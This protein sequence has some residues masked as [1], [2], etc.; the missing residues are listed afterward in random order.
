MP[1]LSTY[2]PQPSLPNDGSHGQGPCGFPSS[3]A[4][5]GSHSQGPRG[6]PSSAAF[7]LQLCNLIFWKETKS[8]KCWVFYPN[9]EYWHKNLVINN[10]RQKGFD[11]IWLWFQTYK[12]SLKASHKEVQYPDCDA[13]IYIPSTVLWAI[14]VTPLKSRVRPRWLFVFNVLLEHWL[15]AV[16]KI[17]QLFMTANERHKR[18]NLLEFVLYIY[19][20]TKL[21]SK[22]PNSKF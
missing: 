7:I 12:N 20:N 15:R 22:Y 10:F 18:R 4:N 8:F 13:A 1:L 14:A 19:Q 3:A 21:K 9:Q 6:F 5:D 11:Q 16:G 17:T 2:K